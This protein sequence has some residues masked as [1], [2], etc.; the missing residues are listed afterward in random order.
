MDGT[1]SVSNA[2]LKDAL[3][4]G[5]ILVALTLDI[6][7]GFQSTEFRQPPAVVRAATVDVM[8]TA[9]SDIYRRRLWG[10]ENSSGSGS[11]RRRCLPYLALLQELLNTT[12][13]K[14]VVDF[15]CGNWE[16]MKH[17]HVPSWIHYLGVDI[18]HSVIE[19]NRLHYSRSNVDFLEISHV[20]EAVSLEG[21][22]L[23]V[24]DVLMHWPFSSIRFF[25]DHVIVNFRIALITNDICPPRIPNREIVAGAYRCLDL[26]RP[27]FNLTA[28][29]LMDW[30]SNVPKRVLMWKSDQASSQQI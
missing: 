5:L 25:L 1:G 6:T 2:W 18:V 4:I 7:Y 12:C 29:S 20:R 16:L 11:E 3:P 15:G 23:V 24:K 8:K 9:F 30:H 19:F 22:I 13:Y 21:D 10:K 27:P 26:Q 14:R 28:I 17:V